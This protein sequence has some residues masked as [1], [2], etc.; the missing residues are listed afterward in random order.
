MKKIF[1]SSVQKEFVK[2]RKQLAKYICNDIEINAVKHIGDTC[3]SEYHKSYRVPERDKR[4][5][6]CRDKEWHKYHS[7]KGQLIC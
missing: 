1:I 5:H 6:Q 7:E 4:Q 2:E 3:K